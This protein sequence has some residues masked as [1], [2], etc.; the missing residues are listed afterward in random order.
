M[1]VLDV[2]NYGMLGSY[3]PWCHLS[4]VSP[5]LAAYK[6]TSNCGSTITACVC[7]SKSDIFLGSVLFLNCLQ[8]QNNIHQIPWVK[9]RMIVTA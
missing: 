9:V 3:R 7:G 6:P 1:C 8:L 4:N 5:M 2:A